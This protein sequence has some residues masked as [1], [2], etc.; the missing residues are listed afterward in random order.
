MASIVSTPVAQICKADEAHMR[1]L[2]QAF[3]E[4]GFESLN[5]KSRYWPAED[6]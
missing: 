1:K 2:I 3:K 6:V 4:F 5:P